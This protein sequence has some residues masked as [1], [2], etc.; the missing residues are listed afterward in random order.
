MTHRTMLR[1]SGSRSKQ[2]NVRRF[3]FGSAYRTAEPSVATHH[4]LLLIVVPVII[5]AV[6]IRII[7]VLFSTPNNRSY[8]AYECSD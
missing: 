5:S 6:V 2:F 8:T 3:K 1:H 4:S 7:V